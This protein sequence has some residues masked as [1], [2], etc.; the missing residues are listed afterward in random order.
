MEFEADFLSFLNEA[1]VDY[2]K[3]GA[4]LFYFPNY[5]LH[6]LLIH[7]SN[8]DIFGEHPLVVSGSFVTANVAEESEV[9]PDI[10]YL[11]E[12]RWFSEKELI[13]SRILLR[14]GHFIPVFARKCKVLDNEMIK[15]SSELNAKIKELFVSSHSYGDAKSKYAFALEYEGIIV[16]AATFSAPRVMTR[17]LLRQVAGGYSYLAYKEDGMAVNG[18]VSDGY[19][20]G[21]GGCRMEEGSCRMEDGVIVAKMVDSYEWVRYASLPGYRIVGGMGRLL[22]AFLKHIRRIRREK[23]NSLPIEVMTYSDTEW[24]DGNVYRKLGFEFVQY[25]PPVEFYIN[26]DSWERISVKKA[27]RQGFSPVG[28]ELSGRFIR[29]KNMG[30]RKYLLYCGV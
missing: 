20:A 1:S 23:G 18:V 5:R 14:L 2:R 22:E 19:G 13:K 11:Y 4:N 27:S 28:E 24:S 30:S 15:S 17:Q 16:A 25:R 12:D 3:T 8:P 21:S 29:V 26:L 10:L 7:L 6:I 9:L